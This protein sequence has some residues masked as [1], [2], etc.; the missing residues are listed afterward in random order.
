MLTK[1]IA[2]LSLDKIAQSGQCFRLRRGQDGAFHAI[3]GT[4][5]VKLIQN[6][7]DHITFYCTEQ[8]FTDIW[9]PYFDLHTDY[10]AFRACVPPEDT[11]LT[12][13]AAFGQGIRILQQ[14]AWEM[15]ITFII[16]QRKN[17]PAIQ[18]AV[19][20]LCTQYGTQLANGQFAFPTP[21]QLAGCTEQNFRDCGLGY[22][23]P[24]LYQ[25]AQLVANDTVSLSQLRQQS[26]EVLEQQ[27]LT[28]TGVGKKI[29]ACVMLFGFHR[30]SAFPCDVW[31]NRVLAQQYAGHFPLEQYPNCQGV[32]Q[33]YLFYYARKSC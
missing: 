5:T 17:I 30:L 23:A 21:A 32:M 27:L 28:I 6:E 1:Q 2:D 25:A 8:E 24:Y 22:R 15:L 31:I 13:A 18:S 14:D 7:P 19:E 16:S 29:A 33:Q 10:A 9:T 20:A 4:H 26:D 12:Q 11:Y 3:T